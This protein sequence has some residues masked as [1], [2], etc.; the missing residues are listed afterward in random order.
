MAG[1][2]CRRALCLSPVLRFPAAPM[3]AE[4]FRC[5][6]QAPEGKEDPL[7][8]SAGTTTDSARPQA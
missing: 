7:I 1:P 8:R 5:H 3:W 4:P 6:I 2:T